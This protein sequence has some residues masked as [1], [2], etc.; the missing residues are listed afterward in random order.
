MDDVYTRICDLT[1]NEAMFSADLYYHKTC[2]LEY[3]KSYSD[4]ITNKFNDTAK[5][6]N[7]ET[8]DI[9]TAKIMIKSYIPEIKCVIDHG[10]GISLSEIREL[11]QDNE[12]NNP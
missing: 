8:N 1:T 6:S 9:L 7:I 4:S 2:Y 12:N 11:V 3:Y 5:T 10:N